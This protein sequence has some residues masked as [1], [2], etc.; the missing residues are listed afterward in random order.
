MYGFVCV[1]MAITI[2]WCI[3]LCGHDFAKIDVQVLQD[4]AIDLGYAE[5][6]IEGR[7][8]A[9]FKWKEVE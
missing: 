2:A 5:F 4:E 8:D 6:V 7:D 3:F 9:V 1:V